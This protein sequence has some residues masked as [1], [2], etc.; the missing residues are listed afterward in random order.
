[1]DFRGNERYAKYRAFSVADES[2][3][4]RLNVGS[5]SGNFNSFS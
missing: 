4:Y 5:Y 3:K 1:M 2:E